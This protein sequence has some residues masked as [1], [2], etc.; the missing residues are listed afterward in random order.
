MRT[1][2]PLV[3]LPL[4]LTGCTGLSLG[5]KA[6][7]S[8]TYLAAGDIA[9]D[10][11]TDNAFVLNTAQAAAGETTPAAPA[12]AL[13]AVQPD[14][15]HATHVIDLTG[16]DN[17]RV[18]FPASG[19]LVMSA[20]D[21]A[22]QLRL[23]DY[24]SLALVT[25]ADEPVLYNGTRMS[26]SRQWFAVADN[27]SDHAP[28]HIFDGTTL[29]HFVVPHGG[30]WLEAMWMNQSDTLMSIVFYDE[31]LPT[32]RA[33]LLSWKMSAVAAGGGAPD[34][35]GFWPA[36]QLDVDIPAINPDGQFS[37]TWVGVSPDDH[38]VAFPVRDMNMGYELVVLDT[39]NGTTRLVA[40]AKGPVG[41]TPDSATIVS[42]RDIDDQGDQELLLINAETLAVDPVTVPITGG[43]TYFLTHQSN[44]VVAASAGGGQR[45]V[46]Y[47]VDNAKLTQMMGPGVGL[48]QFA[49][50]PQKGQIWLV[51]SEEL[52]DLDVA[53]ATFQ[54]VATANAPQHINYLP[55]HD[56]L[57]LDGAGT[58]SLYFLDP[59]TEQVVLTAPLPAP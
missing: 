33:R 7:G 31:N 59:D 21:G 48:D 3:I 15:G 28:I 22:E 18:L 38:W 40:N 51:D 13:F 34:S 25:S 19:V 2:S 1:V 30:D 20:Q 37:F 58:A 9:V 32:A 46:L 39:T 16:R 54:P 55:Q 6:A 36:P 11:R 44:F 8:D 5:E 17:Q 23:F 53:A 26:P 50:R 10:A 29:S 12:S 41:F 42:Y 14:T 45:L 56:R 35:S 43:V 47:D 27:T 57:V 24:Q 52:F 4:L 49:V